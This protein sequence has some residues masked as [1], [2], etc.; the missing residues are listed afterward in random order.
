MPQHKQSPEAD[1]SD[2]ISCT[3]A[4]SS[5]SLSSLRS[6]VSLVN[7]SQSE[8]G[9]ISS[10]KRHARLTSLHLRRKRNTEGVTAILDRNCD[11]LDAPEHHDLA[12]GKL[13]SGRACVAADAS[14]PPESQRRVSDR[15]LH[16]SLAPTPGWDRLFQNLYIRTAATALIHA[17][18]PH[19][20]PSHCALSSSSKTPDVSRQ[21]ATQT[22]SHLGHLSSGTLNPFAALPH[23]SLEVAAMDPNNPTQSPNLA[24]LLT[25]L[26]SPEDA[27]RK[28]A[29]F[30]L[31]SLI[32]DPSF[33]EHFVLSGGLPRLRALILETNGNTLAYSLASFARLLEVDQGWEAVNNQVV[34]KARTTPATLKVQLELTC[35]V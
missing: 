34:Q 35:S 17:V 11:Q 23:A 12:P 7:K 1:E 29:A 2:W 21:Y 14:A 19:S 22:P 27:S 8:R 10:L 25:S 26:S 18:T 30:K 6:N 20:N 4:G 3:S 15:A 5:S 13:V 24:D 9:L 31:Q 32:N 16:A 33:A 28:M